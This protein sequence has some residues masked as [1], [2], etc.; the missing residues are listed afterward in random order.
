MVVVEVGVVL[1]TAGEAE[2]TTT[3]AA[4]AVG[5]LHLDSIPAVGLAELLQVLV[6]SCFST[7][8]KVFLV[9]VLPTTY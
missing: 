6:V 8:S 7:S 2:S 9:D 5:L 4:V 3:T 1:V